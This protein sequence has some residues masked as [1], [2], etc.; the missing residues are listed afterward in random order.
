L[1]PELTERKCDNASPECSNCSRASVACS[2]SDN[3]YP[4]SYV[5]RMEERIL[6][7]E[8]RSS[9][10]G[11]THRSHHHA[12]RP[13]LNDRPSSA[14]IGATL[15]SPHHQPEQP[16]VERPRYAEP[17]ANGLGLLSSCT[18]AEPHYFG[19]SAGLSLAHF[20]QVAIDSRNNPAEV[21]LP[22]LADRPFANRALNADTA[23]AMLPSF[24]TGARYIQAYLSIIHPLYPFLDRSSLWEL[25]EV[26]TRRQDNFHV[27]E[28]H[29]DVALM[30]LVYA[31]GSRCLQLLGKID[32]K[33]STP[34]GHFLSAMKIVNDDLRFTSIRSIEVTL[35]LG[36][37]SMRSPSGMQ[38]AYI[39][40][41]YNLEL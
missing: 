26:L 5:K 1:R 13:T 24:K 33:D 19:F 21:S 25:H 28:T 20:V 3:A 10:N 39:T 7:L 4:S 30:H 11:Q 23:P 40:P 18:A 22:L 16:A 6:Q 36:I 32:K 8:A 9:N 29:I 34:E 35:L 41:K 17:L 38:E 14:S 15:P 37:H 12:Q 31:T 27:P 2:Y